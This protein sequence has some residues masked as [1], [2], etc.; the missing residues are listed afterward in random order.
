MS[1]Q[2]ET[3]VWLREER[4][5]VLLEAERWGRICANAKRLNREKWELVG[6]FDMVVELVGRD[7]KGGQMI[8]KI[9][10]TMPVE[11]FMNLG[12]L[13]EVNRQ[14]LHPR[15]LAMAVM[16]DGDQVTFSH[17]CDYR[18]EPEGVE[19][20]RGDIDPDKVERV[21]VL[22]EERYGARVKLP[23][24]DGDCIQKLDF[25]WSPEGE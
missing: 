19:F 18:D 12:L 5:V 6:H 8:S 23:E 10:K 13:Q 25:E 9:S 1:E 17:I 2:E 20:A 15:G 11:E 21:R 22:F 3:L 24:M 14:F 4:A 7:E 16:I